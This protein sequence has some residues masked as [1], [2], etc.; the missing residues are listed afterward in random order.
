MTKK[1]LFLLTF[2]VLSTSVTYSAEP[3]LTE[4]LNRKARHPAANWGY[5]YLG[6]PALSYTWQPETLCFTDLGSGT[7]IW[8]LS[9]TN[10]QQSFYHNTLSQPPWSADGKKLA[11]VSTRNIAAYSK[12][13]TYGQIWMVS[14]V[15]GTSLRAIVNAASRAYWPSTSP[16][17]HWSPVEVDTYYDFGNTKHGLTSKL[18]TL[19][20]VTVKDTTDFR[21]EYL[22]FP[23]DSILEKTMAATG[24]VVL[25]LK[26]G[27]SWLYPAKIYPSGDK[28]LLDSDG[29]SSNRPHGANAEE[30]TYWGDTPETWS[31]M[32]GQGLQHDGSW[33]HLM[34]SGSSVFWKFSTLGSAADGG[35]NYIHDTTSPYSWGG[36]TEPINTISNTQ[37]GNDP[38]YDDPD[39]A[40]TDKAGYMSHVDFDRWGRV[41]LFNPAL[42]SP[43][44]RTYDINSHKIIAD[45]STGLGYQHGSFKAWSDY[46]V[47]SGNETGNYID[48]KIYSVQYNDPN[49]VKTLLNTYTLYNNDG[50]YNSATYEYMSLVR[51]LLSP[52]GTKVAFHSTFLNSKSGTYDDAPDIFWAVVYFPHPPQISNVTAV[53]GAAIIRFDWNLEQSSRGYTKRGWPKEDTSPPPAP[54]ETKLFR[55]W[56]SNDKTTWQ[57]R[58][59]VEATPF[60]KFDFVNGGVQAEQ[61]SYWQITDANLSDGKWYY[62]ITSMEHSGLESHT[63]SN[64]Y[65]ITIINGN[66]NGIEVG[67]YPIDPKGNS[68]IISKFH[69]RLLRYFNIYAHDGSAPLITQAHRIASISGSSQRSYIDWCGK[70]DGTTQ[71]IVTAVDTLGNESA[72]LQAT[73]TYQ[74]PPASE[75]GQ[76]TIKWVPPPVKFDM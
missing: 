10:G 56:R 33:F 26:R 20:K 38:W 67:E 17:L 12:D 62:A 40:G 24:E 31:T 73:S 54:R 30:Q 65:E 44:A 52:D 37:T 34:P 45:F 50:F 14:N 75:S 46:C 19:Y 35:S 61:V 60:Q 41:A 9:H 47:I 18:N 48:D 6:N 7:E 25:A 68:H 36:E 32:H 70:D 66:G 53:G 57:P 27:E 5:Q 11:F 69:P 63:L 1:I 43:I 72:P 16:N 74:D 28:G 15:D 2:F 58:A 29:Y 71:Y 39:E 3:D 13:P 8:R 4:M 51:P 22:T 21:E 76:Y 42:G 49:S 55:L 64:I 23:E 59:T